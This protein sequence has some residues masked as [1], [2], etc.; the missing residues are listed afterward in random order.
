MLAR[1]R[2][3]MQKKQC[4]EIT[5]NTFQYEIFQSIFLASDA[6]FNTLQMRIA[7]SAKYRFLNSEH[8]FYAK[9]RNAFNKK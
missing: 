6:L 2:Q 9:N 5:K 1:Q 8:I 3:Q 4:S 7:S